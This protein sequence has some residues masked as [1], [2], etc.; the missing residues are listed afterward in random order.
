MR[1]LD[2]LRRST[3]LSG[4][5]ERCV[6]IG[7]RESDIHELCCLAQ[8][9]GTNFLVRSCVDRLAENGGTTIA[10]VMAQVQVSGTYAIRFRDPQGAEQWA[11]LSIKHAFM[12][13]CP[14]IA[15]QKKYPHQTL[16]IVH[17]EEINPPDGR[18]PI[19]WKLIT[20]LTVENHEKA[21]HKLQWYALCRKIETF[22]K[23]LKAGCKIDDRRLTTADQPANCIAP[24]CI[25]AWR[26]S[27]LTILQRQFQTSS[28]AVEFTDTELRLLNK[29]CPQ[30]EKQHHAI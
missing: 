12:T 28:P 7:D 2:N 17:A 6:H 25:V 8:D 30:A 19:F 24:C 20:N 1:W 9:P 5:P 21:V 14:P 10:K 13:V 16:Q 18:A 23:T 15:K 11:V 22:F 29:Q 4:A 26:I 27:C 3:E